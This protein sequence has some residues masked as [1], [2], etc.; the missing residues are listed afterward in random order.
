MV[1]HSYEV[2]TVLNQVQERCRVGIMVE[3]ADAAC[4]IDELARLPL[5]RIYIGLNDLSIDRRLPNIFASLADGSVERICTACS[6]PVGFA[7]LT[8]PEGGA[9]IPCRLLMGE[10]ARLDCSFSILRRAFFADTVG[11]D[12]QVEIA[13]IQEAME[14]ARQRPPHLVAQ[15]RE[16]L[17]KAIQIFPRPL[18]TAIQRACP[19]PSLSVA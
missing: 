15:E 3:T 16:E 13:R 17:L 11:R 18:Y 6:M 8:V 7:A 12:M 19:Q 4:R 2:L 1:R 14:Q 9:P 10:L 5:S